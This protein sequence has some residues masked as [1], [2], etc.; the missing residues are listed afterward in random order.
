MRLKINNSFPGSTLFQG[1][2]KLLRCFTGTRFPQ[3]LYVEINPLVGILGACGINVL[4]ISTPLAPV[5]TH[6]LVQEAIFTL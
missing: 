4:S 2:S 5:P 1:G 6:L 3:H